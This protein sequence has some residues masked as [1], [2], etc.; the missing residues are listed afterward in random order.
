MAR[1]AGTPL[2]D[3]LIQYIASLKTD[4]QRKDGQQ[5]LNRFI[6]WCGRD[7]GV[8]ELTPPEIEEY[9]G[10]A[11]IWGA[12]SAVKLKPVRSFLVYLKEKGLT[13]IGLATHLKSTRSK[14][15]PQRVFLRASSEHAELSPEGFANLQARLEVLKEERIKVVGD[16]QRA[17]ADK[18]FRENA[19]LDAAKE[20]QGLIESSVRELE[21]I[22]TNAVIATSVEDDSE[23]RIRLGKK[24]TIRD[25]AS[26]KEIRYTLVDVREA[27]PIN[28]KLSSVS[29]VGRGLMDKVV[30]DEV[31][32]TVP[33]GT[34]H[35]V[36]LKI[37]P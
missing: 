36:I 1:E 4:A 31:H 5:E 16:I 19:P 20:R 29:P 23:P 2:A 10:S 22:L 3:A 30:G 32:I 18:D 12:D 17:M 35:Y 24:V 21:H 15:G 27:D 8:L 11:G 28:G 9:A 25:V 7:R 37:E 13:S 26:S 34:T 14:K 6:R 33:R